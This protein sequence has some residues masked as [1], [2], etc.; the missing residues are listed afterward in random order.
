MSNSNET[1]INKEEAKHFFIFWQERSV[2]D[3][4]SNDRPLDVVASNQLAEVNPGDTLWVVTL[5]QDRDLFLVGRL[6]VGEI[7]EY[8]EASG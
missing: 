7:V 8:E 3:H 6:I 5:S 1:M 4:A 2:L